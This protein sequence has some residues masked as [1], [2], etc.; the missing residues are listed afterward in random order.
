MDK[1]IEEIIKEETENRLGEMSSPS[2]IFPPKADRK[3]YCAILA[4][5]ILCGILVLLCMTGVIA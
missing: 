4:A 5:I 3:D 1:S 2:Y